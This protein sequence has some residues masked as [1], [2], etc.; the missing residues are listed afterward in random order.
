MSDR[1]SQS[2]D[3]ILE[4]ETNKD[5][6]F[7]IL[8]QINPEIKYNMICS[9]EFD[10]NYQIK[11]C[12]YV[13]ITGNGRRLDGYNKVLL[14]SL[15][16][17]TSENVILVCI[18]RMNNPKNVMTTLS[19]SELKGLNVNSYVKNNPNQRIVPRIIISSTNIYVDCHQNTEN[20]KLFDRVLES[21]N[22]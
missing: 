17:S 13:F 20:K 3:V 21:F 9:N 18:L 19:S 15:N 11:P 8:T 5:I 1:N 14:N 2:V 22:Y 12:F 16:K 6:F 10:V 7:N 4:E